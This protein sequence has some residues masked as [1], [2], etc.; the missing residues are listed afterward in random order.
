ME[1]AGAAEHV[2]VVDPL[3]GTR[4]AMAGPTLRD[5]PLLGSGPDFQMSCVAAGN[6]ELHRKLLAVVEMGMTRL[7]STGASSGS[8]AA[9]VAK[10]APH[11]CSN[12]S[13]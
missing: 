3:D 6:E 11:P 10:V 8:P 13:P 1:P 5:R 9:A 12:P 4:L 7:K 2:L